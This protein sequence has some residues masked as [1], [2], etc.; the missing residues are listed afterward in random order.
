MLVVE[1]IQAV[2]LG[3]IALALGWSPDVP[4]LFAALPA[5]L[6]GTWA[7]VACALLLAGTMRAEAVLALANLIWVLLLGLGLLMPTAILPGALADI[8]RLLPSGALGDALRSAGVHG[9]LDVPALLTLAAWAV[10]AT[11]LASRLFRWSD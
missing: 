11:L 2:V 10:A 4:G 1:A 7:F 8:A 6:L 3:A 9:A 5:V